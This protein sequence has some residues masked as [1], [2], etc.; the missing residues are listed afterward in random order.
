MTDQA[1]TT[2]GCEELFSNGLGNMV[3]KERRIQ[4]W[5]SPGI[6]SRDDEPKNRLGKERRIQRLMS[7]G[8]FPSKG[9]IWHW[10]MY[11]DVEYLT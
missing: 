10:I 4:R 9:C 3:S 6:E 2:K 5:M 1:Y 11:K 8:N 7:L